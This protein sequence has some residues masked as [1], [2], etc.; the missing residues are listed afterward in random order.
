MG[1]TYEYSEYIKDIVDLLNLNPALVKKSFRKYGINTAGAWPNKFNRNG[2][3]YVKYDAFSNEIS[4]TACY[5]L[6]TFTGMI[7]LVDMYDHEFKG[8][9]KITIPAGNYCGLYGDWNGGG[10]LLEMELL[11][12]L[13]I[14]LQNPLKRKHTTKH[15]TAC[16]YVD[17]RGCTGYCIDEVYGMSY[18]FWKND[19]I[20]HYEEEKRTN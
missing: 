14:D 11:R 19:F 9:T 13:T 3:E 12:D 18:S 15:D 17:E 5:T 16:L 2:K 4:N 1:N 7:P 6:L 10:S 8:M 20:I